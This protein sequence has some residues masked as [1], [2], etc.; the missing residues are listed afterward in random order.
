MSKLLK[1]M[2][3]ELQYLQ[4]GVKLSQ[5]TVR[6]ILLCV[7]CDLPAGRKVC[8]FKSSNCCCSKCTFQF[9]HA[10]SHRLNKNQTGTVWEYFCD[11]YDYQNW[12]PR[13][14]EE[15]RRRSMQYLSCTNATQ[16]TNFVSRH[17][18]RYSVLCELDYFNPVTMLVVGN[19]FVPGLF[20][21]S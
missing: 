1:P 9:R 14:N 8:G 2:V 12:A 11:G 6:A 13:S 10:D 19:A 18:V 4:R 17:D 7:S 16:Q 5:C 15:V 20:P 3:D 21:M